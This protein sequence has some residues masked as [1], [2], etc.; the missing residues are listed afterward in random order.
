MYYNGDLHDNSF[1][2]PQSE[3][4]RSFYSVDVS[5]LLVDRLDMAIGY[6]HGKIEG[7]D[8]LSVN[9][10]N[11]KRNL[12]FES[13]VDE[14]NLLFRLKLFR[15]RDKETINPYLMVGVGRLWFNPQSEYQ[16]E[17]VDLQP[18]GTEGQFIKGGDYPDPYSLATTTLA[19]G[20]GAFFQ[21]NPMF[22]VRVEFAPR[23][24]FT[25]YLD[26]VSGNF[27]DSTA[28]ANTANGAMAVEMANNYPNYPK[29][30]KLRGNSDKNDVIITFGAAIV[31]TPW[32]KNLKY[33]KKAGLLHMKGT[34][35]RRGGRGRGWY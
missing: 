17:M 15:Q 13:P 21:I 5:V 31:Y 33:R 16:G 2:L 3:L 23:L 6:M 7:D 25:D 35:V 9:H 12:T 1:L 26:D 22:G 4:I 29:D 34:S 27:A 24:T 8:A 11:R 28:L 14:L 20:A 32:A 30:G 10:Y 19:F 18:L